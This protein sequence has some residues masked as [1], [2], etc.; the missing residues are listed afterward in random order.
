M[1]DSLCL[2]VQVAFLRSLRK[3]HTIVNLYLFRNSAEK[4]YTK[5]IICYFF[6][7]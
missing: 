7:E 6:L 1:S 3:S 2:D 4:C 5:L